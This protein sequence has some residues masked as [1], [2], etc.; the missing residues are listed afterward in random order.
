MSQPSSGISLVNRDLRNPDGVET[1][2]LDIVELLYDASPG[3]A[4]VSAA[5]RSAD[6]HLPDLP[7]THLLPPVVHSLGRLGVSAGAAGDTGANRS[8]NSLSNTVLVMDHTAG[9]KG[10][11]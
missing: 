3:T 9:H 5:S 7:L 4:A 1:H 2:S 11:Y 8:V 10:T 6:F